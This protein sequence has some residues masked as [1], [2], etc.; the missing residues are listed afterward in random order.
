MLGVLGFAVEADAQLRPQASASIIRDFA[1]VSFTHDE[2]LKLRNAVKGRQIRLRFDK[3][4]EV[5]AAPLLNK[6]KPYVVSISQSEDKRS[7]LITTNRDY[8]I[9]SFVSGKNTGIDIVGLK[10][11]GTQAAVK[12]ETPAPKISEKSAVKLKEQV[13]AKKNPLTQARP[14]FK[15][16]PPTQQARKLP[17]EPIEKFIPPAPRVEPEVRN[18]PLAANEEEVAVIEQPKQEAA[19]VSSVTITEEV[20]PQSAQTSDSIKVEKLDDGAVALIFPWNKRVAVTAFRRGN[21]TLVLFNKQKPFNFSQAK[22]SSQIKNITTNLI[23]GET[24]AQL[25][26]LETPLEGISVSRAEKSYAWRVELLPDAKLP[27]KLLRLQPKVEPPLKPHLF[28]SVLEMANPLKF[29]DPLI[30]DELTA[31][32]FFEAG[33]GLT[34]ARR[35]AQFALPRT[36]QGL[37]VHEAIPELRIARTRSGVK[38]TSPEGILL[39][40]D[41]PPV[42]LP[43]PKIEETKA[44]GI[45]FPHENWVPPANEK[46]SAQFEGRLWRQASEEDKKQSR[47]ARKRLAELYLSQGKALE[48]KT[49]LQSLALEAPIYF[50]RHK[51][52]ALLGAAHFLSYEFPQAETAFK[53]ATVEKEPE[54]NFWR[55]ISNIILRGEGKADYLKNH[56]RYIS[57]Y[58]PIM[59]QRLALISADHLINSKQYNKALKIFDTLNKDNMLEDVQDHVNFLIARVLA[60]TTQKDAARLMWGKLAQK[61]QNRYIRPRALFAIT[62]L[63]LAENKISIEEA[64]K[65]LEP[66]RI[67]WRGDQFEIT[68]LNLL[69]RLYE[70]VGQHGEALRTYREIVTYFPNNPKNLEI[71][72]KM[73]DTFRKLF[74]EGI[75]DQLTPLQALALYYEFRNL[76]PIGDEGDE[77]IQNLADRLTSVDLLDRASALLQHQVEFRL[78]SE[79]RSRVGARLALIHLLRRKPKE[80]LSVLELTG[81][82]GNPY[83]LQQQRSL[84]TARALMGVDKSDRALALLT[85]DESREAKLLQLSLHWKEQ[86]WP[87]VIKVAEKLMGQREDPT[88][89]LNMSEKDILMKLAIAYVFEQQRGQLQYLRDYFLPLVEDQKSKD[90]FS[91]ITEDTKLDYRNIA[92]LTAQIGRMESFLATYREKIKE[93]GL[94]NAVQ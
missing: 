44:T 73:A 74:N 53:H 43:D 27:K 41:M 56:A 25:W 38:L 34:P 9:R 70:E 65:Q 23:T 11:G 18:F 51:M 17:Q 42:Q 86:N 26:V 33:R 12:K 36:A 55:D 71:T 91:F 72:G 15:P 82:G 49:L 78:S 5:S 47:I 31:I 63:D 93:D 4:V 48:A 75:A 57:A 3:P 14:S 80:A 28:V 54:L 61:T 89:S 79:E 10:K 45:F 85:G 60:G 40:K 6:L 39:S 29:Y 94:S 50:T 46:D 67:I 24:P 8:R 16:A 66:L 87:E 62:N 35:F 59:R 90:L 22:A 81:Y 83:S 1:R 2:P 77:M 32:P 7:L 88:I 21:R 69:T 20:I 37:V 84:L 19:P 92:K 58:P 68:L 76:T 52:Y 30:G 13:K 64:I